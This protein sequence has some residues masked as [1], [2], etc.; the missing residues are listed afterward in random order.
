MHRSNE[1]YYDYNDPK[2]KE[3]R[4][5]GTLLMLKALEHGP[6]KKVSPS[7]IAAFNHEPRIDTQL[8]PVT[9][10]KDEGQDRK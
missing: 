3:I 4:P 2:P 10:R 1:V 5:K 6:G 7:M 8:P 9:G